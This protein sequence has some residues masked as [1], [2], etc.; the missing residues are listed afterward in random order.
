VRPCDFASKLVYGHDE[1]G[2]IIRDAASM[3]EEL[4]IVP[5]RPLEKR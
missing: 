1:G 2:A 3:A 4:A 5:Y